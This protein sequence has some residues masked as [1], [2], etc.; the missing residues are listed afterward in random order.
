M[1][2]SS[3]D[4]EFTGGENDSFPR[5][6]TRREISYAED[7]DVDGDDEDFEDNNAGGGGG[8]DDG[9]AD[10]IDDDGGGDDSD[11]DIPLSELAGKKQKAAQNGVTKNGQKNKEGSLAK[12]KAKSSASKKPPPSASSA[13]NGSSSSK[14]YDYPSA[15]LYQ[16]ECDKGL[17]IQR[18]LCRWWYAYK[19]PANVRE[20][21]PPDYDA[22][23][24]F[25]GVFICTSG[26][27]VGHILDTRDQS[28]RPCFQ[29][30]AQKPS[31][32]LKDMLIK[33]IDAQLAVLVNQKEAHDTQS[34]Q[35]ELK[36]MLKWANRIN[37]QKADK[38]AAKVLKASGLRL[39]S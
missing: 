39:Q 7:D 27:N 1:S 9:A 11:D 37:P 15:A 21:P 17:L 30:F 38:E 25:P 3:D 35:R 19:W 18:L 33:A 2:E 36:D 10:A 34:V 24:G 8:D 12:K 5:R 13:N 31:S 32:D 28:A 14:K 22:L 23:D 16:T 29:N 26:D 4:A 20:E 6:R